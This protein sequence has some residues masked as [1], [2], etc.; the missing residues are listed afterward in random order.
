MAHVAGATGSVDHGGVVSGIKKWEIEYVAEVKET[1]D[2]GDVGVAS[3]VKTITKWSGSFEGFK[4]GVP[5]GI[6]AIVAGTFDETSTAN[7]TWTGD[8]IITSI[9]AVSG[10]DD[11]VT[12]AYTFVGTGALAIPTA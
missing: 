8:V 9:K 1:T 6:G 2:F 3:F 11:V 7:Q 4:D 12:Y 5:L 10:A